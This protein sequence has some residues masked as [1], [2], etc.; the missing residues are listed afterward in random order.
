MFI[1]G[2]LFF[3]DYKEAKDQKGIHLTNEFGSMQMIFMKKSYMYFIVS[4]EV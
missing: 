4:S 2:F 3:G 1:E